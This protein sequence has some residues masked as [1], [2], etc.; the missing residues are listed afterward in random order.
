MMLAENSLAT[1][2]YGTPRAFSA[3]QSSLFWAPGTPKRQGTPSQASEAATACAGHLPLHARPPDEPAELDV[4]AAGR[5]G[6]TQSGGR[7]GGSDHSAGT[8]DFTP[9][10]RQ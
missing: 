8:Q 1:S 7:G 4:V 10:Q 6:R 9:V 5:S 3:S 2:I